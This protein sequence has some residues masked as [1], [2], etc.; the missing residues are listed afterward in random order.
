MDNLNTSSEFWF[1]DFLSSV[2]PKTPETSHDFGQ[3]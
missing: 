3:S 2:S 1:Q